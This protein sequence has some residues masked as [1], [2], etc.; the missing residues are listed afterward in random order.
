MTIVRTL[1]S[2]AAVRH[3]PLYQMDVKNAFLNSYFT[4]ELHTVDDVSL[5]DPTLYRELVGCLVYMTVIRPDLAY[6]VHVVS[7]FVSTPCSTHW[8]AL[9]QILCYFHSTIFQGLLLSFTSSLELVAY[10][11]ADWAG[12]VTNRKFIFGFGMFL[13]NSLIS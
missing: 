6:A 7:Q 1:I 4:V 12:D 5:D 10:D 11:D 3:W 13:G 9:V 2:V 8:T